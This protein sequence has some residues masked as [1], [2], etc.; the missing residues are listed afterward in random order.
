MKILIDIGHP[1]HVHYFKN[2]S[3]I[4]GNNRNDILFT[5]RDKD[6]AIELLKHYKFKYVS[7][8]RTHDKLIGKIW[9][10]FWFTLRLLLISL[11]YK[12]DIILNATFYGAFVARLLRKPHIS[13]EDTFNNESTKLFVPFTNVVLTGDYDHPNLGNKE[14]KYAGYQEL[15]YLHPANFNPDKSVLSELGVQEG[16]KYFI[17]RFVS[18]SASH[19][20]GHKGI[21]LKNKILLVD[22]LSKFGK[23]F[24]TSE[25]ELPIELEPFRI[26]IAAHRIHD[27]IAFST[28]LFGESATMASEAAMLGV[29]AFFLDNNGRYYTKDQEKKYGLVFNFTE[30]ETDQTKAIQKAIDLLSDQANKEEWQ[31]RRLKML[32]DKI[33]VTDFL[34]WFVVNYPKSHSIMKNDA[35]F[36]LKF[37]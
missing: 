28:L 32:A 4:M 10:L 34:V 27:A 9:G 5:C 6:V 36:Q 31:R 7:F 1:A 37:K 25:K 24:I 18:W 23:V 13:I 33:N 8:G 29:P 19:D 26:R 2:F 14:I 17:L 11:R 35:A 16:E 21:S 12:P 3:K 20:F 15:L 22:E 30:S